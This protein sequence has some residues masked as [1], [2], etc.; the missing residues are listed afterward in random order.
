M[1]KKDFYLERN[2]IWKEALFLMTSIY[3]FH[4]SSV[5]YLRIAINIHPYLLI[6]S[7]PFMLL[8]NKSGLTDT[9]YSIISDDKILACAIAGQCNI[10]LTFN[11]KDFPKNIIDHL[12]LIA[13]KPGEFIK[14]GG[15][16]ENNV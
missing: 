16:N 4:V 3:S 14:S 8:K 9:K 10:I 12:N 1:Q 15:L 2:I 6:I 5:F 11:I 7:F 13:M